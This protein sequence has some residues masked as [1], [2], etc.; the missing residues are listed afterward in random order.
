MKVNV[1][2]KVIIASKPSDVFLYLSDLR[3]HYLWNPQTQSI[4]S[5]KKLKLGAT[6]KTVNLVLGVK[7]QSNN[8]VTKL[9]SNKELE[10]E[11]N[12]GLVHYRAHFWLKSVRGK[13]QLT[14]TT[15]VSADSNAFAFAAPV[16]KLLAR[17]ELQTDMQA[18]KVAVEHKLT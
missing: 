16:M 15:E 9:V 5:Q 3:Y 17:R 4:S 14:C 6:Y 1:V 13:T 8:K 11:N 7:I 12:T 18:L 10:L 2:T